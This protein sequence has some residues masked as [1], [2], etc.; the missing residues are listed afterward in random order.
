MDTREVRDGL[1]LG[2]E[3]EVA[4]MM[5]HAVV[6]AGGDPQRRVGIV[7]TGLGAEIARLASASHCGRIRWIRPSTNGPSTHD[8]L[9]TGIEVPAM[10]ELDR[11]A[12]A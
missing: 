9:E 7:M 8:A 3:R 1:T 10:P 6:R 4:S 2:Q 12:V 5:D 11:D